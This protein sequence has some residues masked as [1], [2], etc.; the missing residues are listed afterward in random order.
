MNK[1]IT[2]LLGSAAVASSILVAPATSIADDAIVTGNAGILSD[3]IFRGI[4]QDTGVGNGGL[5]LEYMG[6]YAGTWVADVGTGI[7]YDLYA[8]YVYEF[9]SGFYLGAGYTTYQYSDNFDS[10]Y[11]EVNLYT[12]GSAGDVSFDFEYT[13]G[14]YN[15]D[16]LDKNGMIEGEDYTFM[17]GTIGYNGAYLTYGDFGDDADDALGNYVELGY[18]MELGGFEVTGALVH[19][20]DL[21]DGSVDGDD[22]ET[23]AYVSI[24]W[25][26]DVI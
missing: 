5:D 14:E 23:E 2:S 6:F 13:I 11:N 17:A 18:S 20:M 8:G 9:E 1:K 24:S 12:G 16:F 26:F 3:Y 4:F 22:E 19:T 10:E 25:G 15:S 7:E 21:N